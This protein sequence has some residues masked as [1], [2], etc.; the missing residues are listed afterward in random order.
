MGHLRLLLEL[1]LSKG[2]SRDAHGTVSCV[3]CFSVQAVS[4]V[5]G[6]ERGGPAR[7]VVVVFSLLV[8]TVLSRFN[9]TS[10]P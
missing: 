7:E 1:L 4:S 5:L 8:G 10:S 6:G 3:I 2:C 9:E